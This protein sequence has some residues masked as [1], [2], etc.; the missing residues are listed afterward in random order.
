MKKISKLKTV[1]SAVMVYNLLP[2]TCSSSYEAAM[3][4]EA[5][6]ALEVADNALIKAL[7]KESAEYEQQ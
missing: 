2:G 5:L 3:T 1:P 4:V 6:Q 7:V